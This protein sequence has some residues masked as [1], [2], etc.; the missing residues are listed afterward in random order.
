MGSLQVDN[1]FT[2]RFIGLDNL[3]EVIVYYLLIKG[4]TGFGNR[5]EFPMMNTL[6]CMV[7]HWI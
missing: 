3:L 7:T 4:M 2:T 1:L 5:D 6:V